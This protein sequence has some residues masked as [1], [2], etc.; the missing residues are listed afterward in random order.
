MFDT[1]L[2]YI[3]N[4]GTFSITMIS[5][6]SGVFGIISYSFSKNKPTLK[7]ISVIV[8][9]LA[10]FALISAYLSLYLVKIPEL[11]NIKFDTA[12]QT[13]VE[14]GFKVEHRGTTG[15]DDTVI[16]VTDDK[17]HELSG[18]VNKDVVI[19]LITKENFN[20]EDSIPKD[21]RR[22]TLRFQVK[23]VDFY[24]LVHL[25][26]NKS[27]A[28]T[29]NIN[30]LINKGDFYLVNNKYNVKYDKFDRRK[31]AFEEKVSD[32][33]AVD[34]V[35]ENIPYGDYTAY[36]NVEG[37]V[38]F[39]DKIS[40]QPSLAEE[41]IIN[42]SMALESKATSTFYGFNIQ[43]LDQDLKPIGNADCRF[44]RD[45][46]LINLG[47]RTTADG[48]SMYDFLGEK[49]NGFNVEIRYNE[50]DYK[51]SFKVNENGENIKFIIQNDGTLRRSNSAE[52]YNY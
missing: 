13:L 46:D 48:Y 17:G 33:K 15:L 40:L 10:A 42:Y 14:N 3:F 20:S 32:D 38:P 11:K 1:I 26:D 36:I 7:F 28:F 50:R 27:T 52:V 25:S 45:G 21:E 34:L 9:F 6:V 23:K 51:G 19:Y 41:D 2:N 29:D 35:F 30:N 16:K 24:S 37:F 31:V 12:K 47:A 39:K 8:L 4:L 43:F 5:L 18:Y 44:W 49:G 22:C